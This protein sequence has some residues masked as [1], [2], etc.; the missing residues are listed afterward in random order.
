MQKNSTEVKS[1]SHHVILGVHAVTEDVNLHHLVK[2]MSVRFLHCKCKL[3]LV[4][5]KSN[6]HSRRGDLTPPSE[7]RT[8][9]ELV[10][11]C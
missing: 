3:Y 8:V 6:L 5:T 7:G 1:P 4:V 9:K 10:D 2:M 11:I